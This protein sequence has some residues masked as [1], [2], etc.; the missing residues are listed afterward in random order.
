MADAPGPSVQGSLSTR[1]ARRHPPP[2][3]AP[4]G[5][6][7][8]SGG[9]GPVALDTPTYGHHGGR[10][11]RPAGL[12]M[13]ANT[14]R[15]TRVA[16]GRRRCAPEWTAG[17]PTEGKRGPGGRT[18]AVGKTGE[19]GGGVGLGWRGS[20]LGNGACCVASTPNRRRRRRRRRGATRWHAPPGRAAA[21]GVTDQMM[22]GL[23]IGYKGV[24][25]LLRQPIGWRSLTR[26]C[27]GSDS[28]A[29]PCL[30][31]PSQASSQGPG[32]G[33]ALKTAKH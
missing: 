10:R 19:G 18:T 6:G 1:G 31:L 13:G 7:P 24:S 25:H 17:H 32:A 20:S 23:V 28:A 11:G 29:E 15:T 21:V 14:A 22:G 12:G 5:G 4:A 8:L 27:R 26:P 2:A 9:Q 30:R 16:G 3:C 33:L